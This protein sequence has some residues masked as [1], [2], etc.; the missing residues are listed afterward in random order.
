MN[1]SRTVAWSLFLT[2]FAALQLL[3]FSQASKKQEME[4]HYKKWL[5]RDVVYIITD[6]ER[7]VFQKLATDEEKEQF[8]DQFWL[9]RDPDPRTATNEFREE[10]YRRIA[11]ANEK[12]TSGDPG[13]MTDRGRIYIIHGEPDSKESRPD[14][15]A[16]AR[17]IEEGGGTTTVH[18]YEKWRYRYIE[19]L[20]ND[21]ELEFV[22]PTH[23]GKFELAVFPWDKD[24][25]LH[26]GMGPT[27]AEQTR[28]STRANHPGL[29]PAAGGAGYGPE[30]WYR[31]AKDTPFARYELVAKAGAAPVLKHKVLKELVEVSVNYTVLPLAVRQDYFRLNETQVL[32][33][34]TV[35]IQNRDLSFKVESGSHVARMA[36][37]G[38]ITSLGSRIVTEF[39]HD[40]VASFRPE[41]LRNGLEKTSVYQ[42]V[43]PLERNMRYKLDLVVKDLNSG[44]VGIVRQAIIPPAFNEKAL[45]ASSVVLSDTIQPLKALPSVDEMFVLGDVKVLPKLD[46]R[47]SAGM[48]LGIYFQVYNV[49]LDQ[50]SLAPSLYV[51]YKLVKDGRVLK[52]A[53]DENGE[54]T[55][56]ASGQRVVL[57]KTLSLDGLEPGNYQ[58]QVE[59]VDRL[60]DRRVQANG[61][62]TLATQD[63]AALK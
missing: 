12:F 36:I 2:F 5:K 35:Q 6:E 57:V 48:P 9:R 28:L 32:V 39:E 41:N 31:R 52:M 62:F 16:Y 58:I 50:T 45:S 17:P 15:G 14:G 60:S 20:G 18:P 56:F 7:E 27:L 55:Q 33:P 59:V 49:T 8:I 21:I 3:G 13:W 54:S 29:T 4:E 38:S 44:N 24:A 10:H 30:N 61:A 1:H 23:T 42:K 22:D 34:V 53:S 51:Y 63:R 40:I 43:I 47:F 19:G 25:L 37:Y 11:Y 26:L 46:G